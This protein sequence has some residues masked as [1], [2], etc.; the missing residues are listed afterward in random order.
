M[1]KELDIVAALKMM[2]PRWRMYW[3]NASICGCNGC[4]NG[5]GLLH[6]LCTAEEWHEV[7]L[8]HPELHDVDRKLISPLPPDWK[9]QP[10]LV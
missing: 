10:G 5:V 7:M 1:S 4:A 2:P 6:G 8:A 9:P 3:C